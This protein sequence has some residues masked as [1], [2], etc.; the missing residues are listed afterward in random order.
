MRRRCSRRPSVQIVRIPRSAPFL[1]S[2][3]LLA[4][5]DLLFRHGT[6]SCSAMRFLASPLMFRPSPLVDPFPL[7]RGIVGLKIS[8]SR[9]SCGSPQIT[10]SEQ[11]RSS[12]SRASPACTA[13]TSTYSSTSSVSCTVWETHFRG[14]EN[15]AI[16]TSCI[17][18]HNRVRVEM[19]LSV[20]ARA[21]ACVCVMCAVCV[22]VVC[23]SG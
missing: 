7:H 11:P 9:I 18:H 19:H 20:H 13:P 5:L 23:V 10:V 4:R 1:F 16:I 22:C 15:E 21:R 8:K 17:L 3:Q 2:V 12:C 6:D 14:I